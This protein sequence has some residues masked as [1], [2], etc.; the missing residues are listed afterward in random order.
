[1]HTSHLSENNFQT[2]PKKISEIFQ[3]IRYSIFSFYFTIRNLTKIG[4]FTPINRFNS[5]DI[6][7]NIVMEQ[8][9]FNVSRKVNPP[10]VKILKKSVGGVHSAI[11]DRET[12]RADVKN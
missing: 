10:R 3:V 5:F 1:M 12:F 9:F 11:F 2:Y 4:Q 7:N 8:H 6:L